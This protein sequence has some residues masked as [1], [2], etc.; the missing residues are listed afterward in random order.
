M[1]T[2][3][4]ISVCILAYN[5]EKYLAR[6]V[7]AIILGNPGLDFPIYI[8]ANGCT[9]RTYEV[10]CKLAQQNSRINAR[11]I[12]LAS[13]SNAWNVAFSEQTADFLIFSDGDI[14]IAP[15]SVKILVDDL[16][17]SP[18][19][20]ISSSRAFPLF[21]NISAEKKLVGIMQLPLKH[22]YLYGGFYGTKRLMLKKRLND[23]GLEG[24]PKGIT[25][26]DA[27]LE[28]ILKGDEFSVTKLCAFYEP[29]NFN[30]YCRYL[31][32]VRWQNEQLKTIFS[33]NKENSGLLATIN[34]KITNHHENL[35]LAISIP[36]VFLR[37]FFKK[38]NQNKVLKIYES[39]GPVRR[40][41]DRILSEF[42]R[43]DSTK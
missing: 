22:E 2:D 25:G 8:Y 33:I 4:K 35:Y 1:K 14:S 39:L 17:S 9:D 7:N 12:K 40:E 16:E 32:R 24:L 31:A 23:M 36:A 29:P 5:E 28:F 43:S 6:T 19:R 11:E 42:T 30:D 37:F 3:Q 10:A 13:K 20:I 38:I 15:E 27:F 34:R 26:E 21:K 18:N 41:G